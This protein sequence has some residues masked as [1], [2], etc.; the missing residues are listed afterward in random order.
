MVWDKNEKY[1]LFN[2][3]FIY[4]GVFCHLIIVKLIRENW[5]KSSD[6]RHFKNAI[7]I[8]RGILKIILI[9]LI[10]FTDFVLH[11]EHS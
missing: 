4:F 7:L 5:E 10:A 11:A 8:V 1:S 9:K 3:G 6:V 2:T